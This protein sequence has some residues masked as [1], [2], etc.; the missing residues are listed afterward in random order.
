ME[1]LTHRFL[2]YSLRHSRPVKL[3]WMTESGIKTGNVTVKRLDGETFSYMTA[4]SKKT[5]LTMGIS[6]VLSASYARG[7]DGDTMKNQQR[8]S[9]E[10]DEG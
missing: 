6:D 5:P 8:E 1:D 10:N 4:R 9:K 3:V 2:E 7:D